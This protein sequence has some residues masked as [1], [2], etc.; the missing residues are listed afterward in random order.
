MPLGAY[1]GADRV[2][3]P[4]ALVIGY[5]TPPEHGYRAAIAAL[6]AVLAPGRPSGRR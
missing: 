6:V 4:E 5:G 3:A 2:G 1:R